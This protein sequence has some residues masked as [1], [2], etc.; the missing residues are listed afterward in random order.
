MTYVAVPDGVD[1]AAREKG[2]PATPVMLD[3]QLR[4]QLMAASPHVRLIRQRVQ[5]RIRADYSIEDELQF[6]RIRSAA[7]AG[8]RKLTEDERA[9]ITAFDV[10]VE[11]AL[12]WGQAQL[13]KLGF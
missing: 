5:E 6:A 1:L 4:A 10:H 2:D 7:A 12:E 13:A 11:M 8:D 3:L 9:E